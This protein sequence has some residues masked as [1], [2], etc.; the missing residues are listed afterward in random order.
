MVLW[1][2]E[3]GLLTEAGMV[4]SE[5]GPDRDSPGPVGS[6]S[7]GTQLLALRGYTGDP[8]TSWRKSERICVKPT[9]NVIEQM[10]QVLAA[11][12]IP[13]SSLSRSDRQ[14]FEE[15]IQAAQQFTLIDALREMDQDMPPVGQRRFIATPRRGIEEELLELL[16]LEELAKEAAGDNNG[17]T[18]LVEQRE[19]QQHAQLLLDHLVAETVTG[20]VAGLL[21]AHRSRLEQMLEDQREQ[22]RLHAEVVERATLRGT[23]RQAASVSAAQPAAA[24]STASVAAAASAPSASRGDELS[25]SAPNTAVASAAASAAAASWTSDPH[26][27]TLEQLRTAGRVKYSWLVGAVK[28]FVTQLRPVSSNQKGSHL[29][30]HFRNAGPVTLVVP[31]SGGSKDA[32]VGRSVTTRLYQALQEATRQQIGGATGAA[33]AGA[34]AQLQNAQQPR[35][36]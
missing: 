36:Q 2:P 24:A 26:M 30:Y 33:A 31:H 8:R 9:Q 10:R 28:R 25:V 13:E 29:V 7:C 21:S 1:H 19:R 3:R 35:L 32:T 5:L 22:L 4:L 16:I 18:P 15:H 34:G 27:S 17:D 11:P 23:V 20:S 14:R 6:F 12:D